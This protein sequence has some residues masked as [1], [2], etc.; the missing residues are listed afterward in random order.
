VTVTAENRDDLRVAPVRLR[1]SWGI[2]VRRSLEVRPSERPSLT[3]DPVVGESHHVAATN[4]FQ[5]RAGH[6]PTAAGRGFSRLLYLMLLL[7]IRLGSSAEG[8][9]PAGGGESIRVSGEGYTR[10]QERARR[11]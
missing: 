4:A 1:R 9:F 11:V 2:L 10:S 8:W 6:P 7:L 3:F 5:Q